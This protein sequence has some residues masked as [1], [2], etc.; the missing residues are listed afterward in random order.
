[1]QPHFFA[2]KSTSWCQIWI[3]PHPK[4]RMKNR[5]LVLHSCGYGRFKSGLAKLHCWSNLGPPYAIAKTGKR[6][7]LDF[8]S[9]NQSHVGRYLIPTTVSAW[10]QPH[11]W[12]EPQEI[13]KSC[14]WSKSPLFEGFFELTPTQKPIL[15]NRTLGLQS[16]GYGKWSY[17][18][19]VSLQLQ[20]CCN[21]QQW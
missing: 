10:L 9:L 3:E 1:M 19:V 16:S 13:E 2:Q 8:L 11:S 20:Q 12:I 21:V 17:Y 6:G 7:D 15:K 4:I 14:F 5:T 18:F